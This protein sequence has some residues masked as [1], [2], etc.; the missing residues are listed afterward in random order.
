MKNL[1]K[2]KV[3]IAAFLLTYFLFFAI[4]LNIPN[5][6]SNGSTIILGVTDY[7]FPFIYYS[8]HCFGGYYSW[9]GLLGNIL[10]A[11]IIS[12]LSGLIFTRFWL[13]FSSPEFRAE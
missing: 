12:F 11:A 7:G 13:K 9:T 10:F 6:S 1:I 8:A 3:F 4:T 5:S 2:H